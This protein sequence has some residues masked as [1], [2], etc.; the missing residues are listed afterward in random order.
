MCLAADIATKSH[1]GYCYVDFC[2]ERSAL[3]AVKALDGLFLAGFTVYAVLN[4]A[5]LPLPI[6]MSTVSKSGVHSS[7]SNPGHGPQKRGYDPKNSLFS[8]AEST[9]ICIRGILQKHQLD[10]FFEDEVRRELEKFGKVSG[11]HVFI[12]D[13][14]ET[15]D[16]VHVFCRYD[17]FASADRAL[18]A[19]NGRFFAGKRL[20]VEKYPLIR[21]E[22][23][24]FYC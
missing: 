7:A 11:F 3:R 18:V 23:K 20:V 2:E 9:A 5:A 13:R 4:Y 8:L 12:D 1:K 19:L 14:D 17:A 16:S 21:Y 22:I 15:A 24:D 10:E 6:S